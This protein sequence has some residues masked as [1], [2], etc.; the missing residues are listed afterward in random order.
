MPGPLRESHKIVIKGPA[1][2]G[3]D[4][5]RSWYKNLPR[6][7][8]EPPSHNCFH[9]STSKTWHPLCKDLLER[10]SPGYPQDLLLRTFTGSCMD[11]LERNLVGSQPVQDLTMK[12]PQAHCLRTRSADFV[13]LCSRHPHGHITRAISCENLKEK[14]QGPRSQRTVFTGTM[15]GGKIATHSLR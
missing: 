2:A 13:S 10:I 11:L 5:T 12:M 7:Y 9:T 1:A 4:L 8:Q 6:A 15:R 3:A 14:C